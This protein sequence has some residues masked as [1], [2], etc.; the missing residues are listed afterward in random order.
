MEYIL[1]QKKVKKKTKHWREARM[2]KG[3]IYQP[4]RHEKEPTFRMDD[5]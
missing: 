3:K 2:T 5:L 4:T 1:K